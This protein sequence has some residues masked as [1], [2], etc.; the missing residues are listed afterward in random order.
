MEPPHL[1]T[2]EPSFP[3][4]L[5]PTLPVDVIYFLIFFKLL[6]TL[7]NTHYELQQLFLAHILNMG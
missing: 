1:Y 7:K 5:D 6:P 4:I 3:E 2:Y